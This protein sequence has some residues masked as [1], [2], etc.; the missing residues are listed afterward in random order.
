MI[1]GKGARCIPIPPNDANYLKE[2]VAAFVLLVAVGILTLEGII[3]TG[4]DYV[5]YDSDP[6]C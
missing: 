5:L 2:M 6:L 3:C 4:R 1:I